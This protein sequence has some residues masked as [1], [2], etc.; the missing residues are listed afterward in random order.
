M[1][2]PA[3]CQKNSASAR[4]PRFQRSSNSLA[5]PSATSPSSNS[6]KLSPLNRWPS[7]GKPASTL[8]ASIPTVAPSLSAIPSAAPEQNSPPPSSANCSAAMRVMAWSPCASAAAWA[9]PASSSASDSW[10]CRWRAY[11]LFASRRFLPGSP[12]SFVL[13]AASFAIFRPGFDR[14]SRHLSFCCSSVPRGHSEVAMRFAKIVFRIAGI[15]G[16]LIITPLYFMFDL[17]GR[18][19]P[20]PITHPGFFYGFVGVALVLQGRMHAS[21][22]VFAGTDLLLGVL[23]VIAYFKTPPRAV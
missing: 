10:F 3:F 8:R 18:K 20:P 19:D 22:L 12:A 21:D 14:E 17:I 16:V 2:P 7:S 15:W 6:T 11:A 1:P 9:P 5:S 13:V 4:S 23:F